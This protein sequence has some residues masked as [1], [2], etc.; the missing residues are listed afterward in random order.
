MATA[1]YPSYSLSSPCRSPSSLSTNTTGTSG[2][3]APMPLSPLIISDPYEEYYRNKMNKEKNVAATKISAVEGKMPP[4][5]STSGSSGFTCLSSSSSDEENYV[6][7]MIIED[8]TVMLQRVGLPACQTPGILPDAL[9]MKSDK[10]FRATQQKEIDTFDDEDTDEEEDDLEIEADFM[11]EDDE[12]TTLASVSAAC[13]DMDLGDNEEE[14]LLEEG[15]D[16]LCSGDHQTHQKRPEPSPVPPLLEIP[17][18]YFPGRRNCFVHQTR[19]GHRAHSL[20]N[21]SIPDLVHV[22]IQG[23]KYSIEISLR[24]KQWI[25]LFFSPYG[26]SIPLPQSNGSSRASPVVFNNNHLLSPISCNTANVRIPTEKFLVLTKILC[27]L[28]AYMNSILVR[29][30]HEHFMTN[31]PMDSVANTTPTSTMK[32]SPSTPSS[33]LK[34]CGTNSTSTNKVRSSSEHSV[35]GEDCKKQLFAENDSSDTAEIE[36]EIDDDRT[37]VGTEISCSPT[38]SCSVTPTS[39]DSSTESS[40]CT[41]QISSTATSH[42]VFEKKSECEHQNNKTT[43]EPVKQSTSK[44]TSPRSRQPLPTHVSYEAFLCYWLH[45]IAPY[46]VSER[47]YRLLLP[48]KKDAS[49]ATASPSGIAPKDLLALLQC[50]MATHPSLSCLQE[51][52]QYQFDYA[53]TVIARIFYACNTSRSGTLSLAEFKKSNL[54]EVLIGLDPYASSSNTNSK[55]SSCTGSPSISSVNA[56]VITSPTGSSGVS[57]LTT[58]GSSPSTSVASSVAP[59]TATAGTVTPAAASSKGATTCSTPSSPSCPISENIDNELFFFSYQDF[60]LLYTSFQQMIANRLHRLKY[61]AAA[62]AAGS[63]NAAA[64]AAAYAAKKRSP[65][66]SRKHTTT[67]GDQVGASSDELLGPAILTKED[68]LT[69]DDRVFSKDIVDR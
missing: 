57:T 58:S 15:Q 44:T 59:A 36:V 46:D 31:Y 56:A 3:S 27:Q 53:R 2:C 11:V 26:L 4:T 16:P 23:G 9:A 54:P 55:S 29:R 41:S 66:K 34:S 32:S 19:L 48:L 14:D 33:T 5:P 40:T 50:I 10:K 13:L 21:D 49:V 51:F 7:R 17:R 37:S 42:D 28:P 22:P 8:E 38:S 52:P 62:L 1:S 65:R 69:Y 6:V 45:E 30:I 18:F 61:I 35:D 25:D 67:A 63:P 20:A 68:M 47:L 43:E 64:A 12:S 39:R 24:D 60:Y